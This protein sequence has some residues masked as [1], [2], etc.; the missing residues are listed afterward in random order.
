MTCPQLASTWALYRTI[1]LCG[2]LVY[3]VQHVDVIIVGGSHWVAWW[4]DFKPEE[5][6]GA[7]EHSPVASI[8]LEAN[9]DMGASQDFFGVLQERHKRLLAALGQMQN[10]KVEATPYNNSF[11]HDCC[12]FRQLEFKAQMDASRLSCRHH[13]STR[14]RFG[15]TVGHRGL[16]WFPHAAALC[17]S[18]H[19]GGMGGIKPTTAV[20][21]P[22]EQ[23]NGGCPPNSYYWIQYYYHHTGQALSRSLL[24]DW[25]VL[26]WITRR[27]V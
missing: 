20:P 1:D 2:V 19:V 22:G 6:E 10:G 21:R 8:L 23:R 3:L 18:R 9:E 27:R 11:P 26:K 15:T 13:F 12:L 17:T 14:H 16:C 7:D 25:C 24:A 5:H 4:D